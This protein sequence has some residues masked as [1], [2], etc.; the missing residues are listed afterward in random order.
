MRVYQHGARACGLRLNI[1][2]RR[3]LVADVT[4]DKI[5]TGSNRSELKAVS[6]E[7][8]TSTL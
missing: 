7:A 3:A 5:Y 8:A 4:V 6:I 2:R 1:L